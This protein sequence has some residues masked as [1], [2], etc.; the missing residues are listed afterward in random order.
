MLGIAEVSWRTQRS[1]TEIRTVMVGLD[2][3]G[4]ASVESDPTKVSR[5]GSLKLLIDESLDGWDFWS[6]LWNFFEGDTGR[7]D[8]VIMWLDFTLLD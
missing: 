3:L 6:D 2:R 8:E 1:H 4:Y 5:L 7:I